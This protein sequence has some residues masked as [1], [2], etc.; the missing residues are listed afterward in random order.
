[1]SVFKSPGKMRIITCTTINNWRLAVLLSRCRFGMGSGKRDSGDLRATIN[2]S[3]CSKLPCS[4]DLLTI[5]S[6]FLK[7]MNLLQV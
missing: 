4:G 3:Q 5:F 2:I 7:G 6:V 1:M